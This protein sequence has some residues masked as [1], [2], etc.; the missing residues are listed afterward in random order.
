MLQQ[1]QSLEFRTFYAGIW[2]GIM[3]AFRYGFCW[4]SMLG[5]VG[6]SEYTLIYK[7]IDFL[8]SS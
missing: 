8:L 2:P 1:D 4:F 7:D 6:S 3:H 5:R